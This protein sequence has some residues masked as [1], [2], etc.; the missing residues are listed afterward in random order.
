MCLRDFPDLSILLFYEFY[1]LAP[2]VQLLVILDTSLFVLFGQ[3]FYLTFL[4]S[5]EFFQFM[6]LTEFFLKLDV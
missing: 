6:A 3:R 5:I 2:R 4:F 1:C